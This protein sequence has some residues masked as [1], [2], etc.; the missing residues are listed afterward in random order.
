MNRGLFFTHYLLFGFFLVSCSLSKISTGRLQFVAKGSCLNQVDETPLND[1]KKEIDA[2]AI[3]SKKQAL[4]FPLVDST[5][6]SQ[7]NINKNP[8]QLKTSNTLKNAIELKTKRH[9]NLANYQQQFPYIERSNTEKLKSAKNAFLAESIIYFV[10][11]V[12][13]IPF[14]VLILTWGSSIFGFVIT[15]LGVIA[16]IL[17]IALYILV[18]KL[19]KAYSEYEAHQHDY[20]GAD[21]AAKPELKGDPKAL[22]ILSRV[23]LVPIIIL[24]TLVIFTLVF[25]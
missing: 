20:D 21:S 25:L 23:G 15:G 13:S 19:L 18:K 24:F 9:I 22:Y 8:T 12:L 16:T 11:S 6:T 10:L 17:S 4:T 14:A 2:A 3:V 7:V 1:S 5:V